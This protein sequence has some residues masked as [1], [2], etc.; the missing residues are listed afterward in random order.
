MIDELELLR[1]ARPAVDPP[2]EHA[3]RTARETLDRAIARGEHGACPKRDTMGRPSVRFRLG[4]LAAAASILVVVA[5]VAVFL[6]IRGS[7]PSIPS[8]SGTT[9]IR[10][11]PVPAGTPAAA[12]FVVARMAV[13][14]RPQTVRDRL[15]ASVSEQ[16]GNAPVRSSIIPSLTRLAATVKLGSGPLE[17]FSIYVIVE[18]Q[19]RGYPEIATALVVAHEAR[20]RYLVTPPEVVDALTAIDTRGLTPEAVATDNSYA[21][22]RSS[23][24][25][26]EPLPGGKG[27]TV[28][29]VPDGVTRVKWVFGSLRRGKPLTIYPRVENNLAI[30]TTVPATGGPLQATWYDADGRIVKPIPVVQPPARRLPLPAALV[31]SFSAFRGLTS[32]QGRFIT[33]LDGQRLYVVPQT[34][35]TCLIEKRP[36]VTGRLPGA[37][38]RRTRSGGGG[39]GGCVPNGMALEG[40]FT[41]GLFGPKGETLIGVAPNGNPT[42]RLTLADRSSEVVRV[43]QNVYIAKTSKQF[44]SVTLKDANGALRTWRTS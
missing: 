24:C 18:P 8:G 9:S 23:W 39:G 26:S 19:S 2:S 34:K 32:N 6:G 10:V 4:R 38:G 5:V 22:C 33:N 29:V 43:S 30:S 20:N 35:Q 37:A 42:V 11:S 13:L 12:R 36:A 31:R 1:G 28:A 17:S 15:P 7:N 44:T 21:L 25:G 3:R 14:R 27:V 41:L 40:N 16:L